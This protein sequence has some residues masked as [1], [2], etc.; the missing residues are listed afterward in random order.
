MMAG[1]AAIEVMMPRTMAAEGTLSRGLW[2]S[3]KLFPNLWTEMDYFPIT[4]VD[5]AVI[6]LH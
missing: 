6:T 1:H 5:R 4:M 3:K 2:M